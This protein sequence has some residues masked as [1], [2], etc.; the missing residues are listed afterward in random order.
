M[1]DAGATSD[2]VGKEQ[3]RHVQHAD[4][5]DELAKDLKMINHP[6]DPFFLLLEVLLKYIV[7]DIK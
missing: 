5:L 4:S 7:Y 2:V 3:R 1:A 6:C